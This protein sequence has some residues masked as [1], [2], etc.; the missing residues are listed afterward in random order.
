ELDSAVFVLLI[1]LQAIA[2][3]P[4]PMPDDFGLAVIWAEQ[5]IPKGVGQPQQLFLRAMQSA[6]RIRQGEDVSYLLADF[7]RLLAASVA[8]TEWERFSVVAAAGTISVRLAQRDPA[9]ASR[10]VLKA[11]EAIRN[12]FPRTTSFSPAESRQ[13]LLQSL[14]FMATSA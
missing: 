14:W 6:I 12:D 7:D 1:A 9:R 2:T 5:P 3:A 8:T 4:D 11:L 13:M 10:Y